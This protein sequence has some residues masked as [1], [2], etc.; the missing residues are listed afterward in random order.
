[1]YIYIYYIHT[2]IF[3]CVF[4]IIVKVMCHNHVPLYFV[5]FH[6]FLLIQA[7]KCEKSVILICLTISWIK[8][9]IQR[10]KYLH[11][12]CFVTSVF[13]K[14]IDQNHNLLG[15]IRRTPLS[16]SHLQTGLTEPLQH[17]WT[18]FCSHLPGQPAAKSSWAPRQHGEVGCGHQCAQA[19]WGALAGEGVK[20]NK[21]QTPLFKSWYL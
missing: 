8:F 14:D 21:Q 15:R 16:A 20:N 19:G 6:S 1:M 17:S 7:R 11:V 12:L 18:E 5:V 4:Y 3:M 10:Q 2:Y 13:H 9:I